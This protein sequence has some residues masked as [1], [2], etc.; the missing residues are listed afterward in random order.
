MVMLLDGLAALKG[1]VKVKKVSADIDGSVFKLHYRVTA[2]I[3][4][5]LCLLVTCNSL[6]G[7]PI[8]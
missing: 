3:L 2:S 5:L 4:F 6:I 8:Q 1:L 7:D